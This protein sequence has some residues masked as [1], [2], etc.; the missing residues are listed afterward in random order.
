MHVVLLDVDCWSM[1]RHLHLL[2]H[3][4]KE[5]VYIAQFEERKC[6]TCPVPSYLISPNKTT[7]LNIIAL[8]RRHT[9]PRVW[10]CYNH[11]PTDT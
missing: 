4:K 5:K 1:F 2:S 6:R 8:T 7:H 9:K 11:Q 3:R 10:L